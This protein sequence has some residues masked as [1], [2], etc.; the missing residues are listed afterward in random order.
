MTKGSVDIH[1]QK[2]QA[3]LERLDGENLAKSLDKGKFACKQ[4]EWLGYTIDSEGTTPL[5]RKTDAIEKLCPPKSLK[6]LKSFMGSIYH[7]TRYIP[8]LA[9]RA[10]ALRP[11]LK[12]NL[13]THH[14]TGNRNTIQHLRTLKN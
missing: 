13:K 3:I 1:K 10:A 7:L 2:L 9:Q 8:N 11:L 14:L 6:Q 5:I 4:V 12:N